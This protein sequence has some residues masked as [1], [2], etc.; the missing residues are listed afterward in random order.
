MDYIILYNIYN[1]Y[2]YFSHAPNTIADEAAIAI[3][4]YINTHS[5]Q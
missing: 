3:L 2:I 4:L 5:E 1:I